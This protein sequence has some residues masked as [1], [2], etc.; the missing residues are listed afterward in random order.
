MRGPI[1]KEGAQGASGRRAGLASRPRSEDDVLRM[2]NPLTTCAATLCVQ[3][4]DQYGDAGLRPPPGAQHIPV[5]GR[6]PAI[7]ADEA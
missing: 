7:S 4:R 6:S 2:W 1:G 5:A 3:V